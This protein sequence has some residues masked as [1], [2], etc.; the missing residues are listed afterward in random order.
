M[1][2]VY[3]GPPQKLT[4]SLWLLER[5]SYYSVRY[6]YTTVT[7]LTA[8]GH[9]RSEVLTETGLNQFRR[10]GALASYN[11]VPKRRGQTDAV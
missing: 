11:I 1:S 10:I 7:P 3:Y 9:D 6:S 4:L 8:G 2:W 5:I